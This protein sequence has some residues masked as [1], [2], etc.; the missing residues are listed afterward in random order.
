MCQHQREGYYNG[1]DDLHWI[2]NALVGNALVGWLSFANC[3][4]WVVDRER[5]I[6]IIELCVSLLFHV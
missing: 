5:W 3:F 1:G 2:G 4:T 6:Y